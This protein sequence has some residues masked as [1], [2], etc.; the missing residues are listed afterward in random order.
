MTRRDILVVT[1]RLFAVAIVLYTVRGFPTSLAALNFA[2]AETPVTSTF[3]V[4]VHVALI[5][6]AAA[7]W[8]FP[9]GVAAMLLPSSAA[10]ETTFPWS[11]DKVIETASVVIGLFYLAY[12]LSDLIY[13]FSFFVAWSKLEPGAFHL[14]AEQWAGIITTIF[15]VGLALYLVFGSQGVVRLVRAT[16]YAGRTSSN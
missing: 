5:L 4:G 8:K 11:Q 9:N 3:V 12:A 2:P 7:L 6:I 14:N 15:E 1:V 13:W 10:E 16:R